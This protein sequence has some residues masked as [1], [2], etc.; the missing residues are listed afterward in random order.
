MQSN[1][2]NGEVWYGCLLVDIDMK[3]PTGEGGH[4]WLLFAGD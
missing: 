3:K 2:L 1:I 4:A